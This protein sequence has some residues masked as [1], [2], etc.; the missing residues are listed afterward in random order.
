MK[1]LSIYG[2]D[3]NTSRRLSIAFFAI[4]G[5]LIVLLYPEREKLE[6]LFHRVFTEDK[7]ITK[8][9]NTDRLFKQMCYWLS[10][11]YIIYKLIKAGIALHRVKPE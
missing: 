11:F 8:G 7:K 3:Y 5:I 1:L 2:L 10:Y 6:L 9:E 4:A